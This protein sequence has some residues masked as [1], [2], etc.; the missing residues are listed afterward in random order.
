V[1]DAFW[2]MTQNLLSICR[3]LDNGNNVAECTEC[4]NLTGS[5]GV[6][7]VYTVMSKGPVRCCH[8]KSLTVWTEGD[9]AY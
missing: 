2:T 9:T 4:L 6:K 8:N 5:V 1:N 3:K 7:H